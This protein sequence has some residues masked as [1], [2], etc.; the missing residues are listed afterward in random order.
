MRKGKSETRNRIARS[1][2]IEKNPQILMNIR[3]RYYRANGDKEK[4]APEEKENFLKRNSA[5]EN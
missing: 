3:S 4:S 2:H 5:A 1:K